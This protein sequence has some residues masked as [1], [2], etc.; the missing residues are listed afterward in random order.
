MLRVSRKVNS[1]AGEAASEAKRELWQGQCNCPY[2]HGLF[3]GLYLNYLRFANYTHLL[4]AEQVA[5]RALHGD[6]PGISSE[7]IDYDCDGHEEILV[8]TADY[9]F[10]VSPGCGGSIA[11]I[12]YK[13]KHFN[14][15]DVMS[16]RPEAYHRKIAK[17]ADN[18]AGAEVKSIHDI[19]RVKEE[20][21]EEN[22]YYDSYDR[23]CFLDHFL[24]PGTTVEDFA[25][26]R[27]DEEGDFLSKPYELTNTRE[28]PE[29]LI[30]V[31]ERKGYVCRTSR[32]IQAAIRKEFVMSDRAGIE[33][34]YTIRSGEEFIDS[35][36][37]AVELNLTL[38]AEDSE[39]RYYELPGAGLKQN[40]M[41]SMGALDSVSL[42]RLV[43][44]WMQVAIVIQY[45]PAASFWRF[46]IET[47]SQ[48][49]GGFEKTYQGSSV[50]AVWPL[51][52]KSA[53][54]ATFSVSLS[55][56]QL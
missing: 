40:R 48:S 5:D 17:A 51:S 2:W 45:E 15:T 56:E 47:V 38:L 16:R 32:A 25:R 35:I 12:G 26:A 23:R 18:P 53:D 10:T 49:E 36:L 52:L 20:G 22:L 24:S 27:H 33:A 21:L 6:D 46:P 29:E 13:P 34:H 1:L 30:L 7:R 8:S 55:V 41:K 39:E 31:L 43:D 42:V 11:E 14:I 37:F 28:S 19:V 50:T 4:H 44:H 54:T 9:S 3:G